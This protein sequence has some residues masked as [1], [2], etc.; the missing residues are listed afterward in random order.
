MRAYKLE[1][2]ESKFRSTLV[3]S[4]GKR[5]KA[6]TGEFDGIVRLRTEDS[7]N[8]FYPAN[9]KKL[10][11]FQHLTH[12]VLTGDIGTLSQAGN[13]VSTAF[14]VARDGTVYQLFPSSCWAYHLGSN[15]SAPNSIWS[16]RSVGIEASCI[17]PLS[18]SPTDSNILL[19]A[20]GK[21]YCSK[22]DHEFYTQVNYRGYKYYATLTD[23]Q[24]S[25]INNLVQ[26]L[27]SKHGIEFSKNSKEKAFDYYP[28]IPEATY[29]FHSNVR[30][31]KV[32]CSPAFEID[33]I[34]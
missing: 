6:S 22:A 11:I 26:N 29:I 4:Y 33:K 12:G 23:A 14:V 25:S 5:W 31:D 32:D 9:I 34:G 3:D 17:G 2:I 16:P 30:K 10:K 18:E 8:F 19:D 15:T 20:Y 28:K 1:E 13:H 7:S 21:P 24:Y 27:C